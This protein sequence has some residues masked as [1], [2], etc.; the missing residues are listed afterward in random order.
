M[1]SVSDTQFANEH[2]NTQQNTQQKIDM[3]KGSFTII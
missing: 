2:P 1:K 3:S